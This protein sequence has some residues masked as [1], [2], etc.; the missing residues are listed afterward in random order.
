MKLLAQVLIV[1][2]VAGEAGA[3]S[4]GTPSIRLVTYNIRGGRGAADVRVGPVTLPVLTGNGHL[5]AISDAMKRHEVDIAGLQEVQQRCLVSAFQDEAARIAGRLGY[6]HVYG[7]ASTVGF[8][9]LVSRQGNAIVSRWPILSSF[10]IAL[11][12]GKPGHERR[13]AIAARIAVPGVPGGLTVVNTHL[14]HR[15]QAVR[16]HQLDLL[17]RAVARL[18][19]PVV[20]CGDLNSRVRSVPIET[21]K[22]TF[23]TGRNE[24]LV[25]TWAIAG[26]GGLNTIPSDRPVVKIDWVFATPGLTP[27]ASRVLTDVKESDHLPVVVELGLEPAGAGAAG[28]TTSTVRGDPGR[29]APVLLG[30]ASASGSTTGR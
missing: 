30:L 12:P 24:S 21:I 26:S 19:G 1:L 7:T 22:R 17:S 5:N 20:L 15:D 10:E 9:G 27:V 28:T 4:P 6:H 29:Q 11:P 25:D 18:D 3:A 23:R 2:L 13:A 16:L 14:D 8:R